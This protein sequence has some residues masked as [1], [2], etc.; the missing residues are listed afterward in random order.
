MEHV[1]SIVARNMGV[2][3]NGMHSPSAKPPHLGAFHHNRPRTLH[4]LL[5]EFEAEEARENPDITLPLSSLRMEAD[6]L[7]RVPEF[8]M[9]AFTDWSRRQCAALL[10]VRFDRWF[11][12]A[13]GAER[14]EEM[15]RRLA[16]ASS[17][18]RLRTAK[19]KEP[20][21]PPDQGVDGILRAFVTPGYS[22]VADSRLARLVMAALGPREQELRLVRSDVTD[23]STTYVVAIGEPYRKGQGGTV[24]EVWGGIL[25]RNSG[26]GFASLLVTLHLTRLLC[27]NGMVAPLPDALVVRRRHRGVDDDA[28]RELLSERLADLPGRLHEGQTRLLAAE[29]RAVTDVEG[30]VRVILD[31]AGL[32]RRHLPRIVAAYGREPHAS[33]FGVSQAI[34]LAAQELAPEER[35]ELERAAGS[36]LALN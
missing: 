27:L 11:E 28:L 9:H 22:P 15:N 2:P 35:F 14:A 4:D 18:V 5:G 16:R 21:A 1:S 7:I 23:R 10:G 33:A 25:V 34:T 36:Y 30:T 17:S 13:T 32:P 19:M 3:G 26:V 8:G 20:T 6:G 31:E 24:G 29:T 12:N